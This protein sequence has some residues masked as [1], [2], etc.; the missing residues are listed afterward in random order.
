MEFPFRKLLKCRHALEPLAWWQGHFGSAFPSVQHFLIP[1]SGRRADFFPCPDNPSVRMSI[2]ESGRKYRAF[3]PGEHTGAI[4]DLVLDWKDVQAHR[5]GLE[6]VSDSLRR[7]FNLL[8]GAAPQLESLEFIGRCDCN[9]EFRH[10]F[11]CFADSAPAT[12]SAVT[13]LTDPR[14]VG[15]I[16]FPANHSVAADLLRS[17][18][19]ASVSLRECLSL[20]KTGFSGECSRN[21]SRCR[22]PDIS[23]SSLKTHLDRRLDTLGQEFASIKTENGQLKGDLAKMIANIA[24]QVDPEYFQWIYLILA[25]GSASKAAA[26]LKI[27][28]STFARQIKTYA[29]RGGLYQTL[30]DLTIARKGCGVKTVEHYNPDFAAHQ[31]LAPQTEEA[32]RDLLD[33]LEALNATNWKT[34]RKELIEVVKAEFR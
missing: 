14:T 17:R 33:G 11:A 6:Q 22:S 13:P 16:L 7:A 23:I 31:L 12:I 10:V 25:S 30:F 27:P 24:S 5:I 26:A 19:I 21:C 15:C 1:C 8:P 2:R 28:N 29:D 32:V 4:E 3:P 20:D 9:G 34:V 18:G